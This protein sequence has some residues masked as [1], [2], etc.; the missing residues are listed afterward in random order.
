MVVREEHFAN[1]QRLITGIPERVNSPTEKK[2]TSGRSQDWK[3]EK[4][5]N[6]WKLSTFS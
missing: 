2:N 6:V 4:F 5:P 3:E 1:Y